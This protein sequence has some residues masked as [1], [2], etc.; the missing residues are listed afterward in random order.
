MYILWSVYI[1]REKESQGKDVM[2]VFQAF[3]RKRECNLLK[4]NCSIIL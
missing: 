2:S 4:I 1:V 3:L